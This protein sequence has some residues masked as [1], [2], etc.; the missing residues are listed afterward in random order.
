MTSFLGKTPP[1][2]CPLTVNEPIKELISKLGSLTKQ[3][4]GEWGI[5]MYK[6]CKSVH[7]IK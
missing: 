1:P 4:G 3:A 2:L 6:T 7:A 5:Y